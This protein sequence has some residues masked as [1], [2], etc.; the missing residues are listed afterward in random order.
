MKNEQ[1][2]LNYTWIHSEYETDSLKFHFRFVQFICVL[3]VDFCK[4]EPDRAREWERHRENREP[5]QIVKRNEW[6]KKKKTLKF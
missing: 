3:I 2:D 4:A 1:F 6:I 5:R